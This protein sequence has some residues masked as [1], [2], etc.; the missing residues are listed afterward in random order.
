MDLDQAGF[1]RSVSLLVSV[2]VGGEEWKG[3]VT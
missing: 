1:P 3:E 2:P